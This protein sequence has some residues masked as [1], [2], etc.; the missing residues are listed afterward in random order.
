MQ[1]RISLFRSIFR[2]LGAFMLTVP[3]ACR[4]GVSGEADP[5]DCAIPTRWRNGCGGT[6]DRKIA[7]GTDEAAG[8]G[9]TIVPVPRVPSAHRRW[10]IQRRTATRC[11]SRRPARWRSISICMRS[12]AIT[13][14]P[15][16]RRSRWWPR[17]R[18]SWSCIVPAV[19]SVGDSDRARQEKTGSVDLRFGW[20][21]QFESPGAVC[22][23]R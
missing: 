20:R 23:K 22:W 2:C 9:R 18:T 17:S 1:I 4:S 16:F 3:S 13:R 19:K 7:V 14:S 21:R 8:S 5:S 10:S 6:R 11:S 12:C 15:I